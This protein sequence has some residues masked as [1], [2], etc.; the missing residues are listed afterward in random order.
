MAEIRNSEAY[1]HVVLERIPPRAEPPF[2]DRAM[3]ERVWGRQWGVGD[4]VGRL[5][6]VALHR[7]GA[8]MA[9]IDP[10]KY[11]ESI[12]ALIDDREQWY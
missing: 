12:E 11:D 8:E 7:P 4:D 10:D 5:R 6:L 3:Q 2:E 9:T 1:Y